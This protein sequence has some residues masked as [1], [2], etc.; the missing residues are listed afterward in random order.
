MGLESIEL[1]DIAIYPTSAFPTAREGVRV[2]TY[3]AVRDAL[4][5]SMTPHG[6]RASTCVREDAI[7]ILRKHERKGYARLTAYVEDEGGVAVT[8]IVLARDE[9]EVAPPKPRAAAG[10]VAAPGKKAAGP[11]IKAEKPK[12]K[13]EAGEEGSDE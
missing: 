3:H 5:V 6:L 13:G 10:G 9:R 7:P 11:K 2:N 8:H 12:P 4:D 1:V